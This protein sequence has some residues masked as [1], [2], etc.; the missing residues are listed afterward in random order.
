MC[1]RFEGL[2]KLSGKPLTNKVYEFILY[3]EEGQQPNEE[4]TQMK[5]KNSASSALKSRVL[6][7]TRLIPKLVYEMEQFGKN[8]IALSKKHNS[9]LS[10]YVGIG[11]SRDF[12]IKLPAL[13]DSLEKLNV[14]IN[15]DGTTTNTSV[16]DDELP[17]RECD[18]DEMEHNQ[19]DTSMDV[20]VQD[21]TDIPPK[22]KSKKSK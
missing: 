10:K 17:N 8:V 1:F 6:R 22:K 19:A 4:S 18:T 13:K 12:R 11:T 20:D 9:D 15:A 16:T 5:R 7:E 14:T 21:A 2:L 3:I